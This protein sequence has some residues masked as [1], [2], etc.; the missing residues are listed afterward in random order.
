MPVRRAGGADVSHAATWPGGGPT[1][2][3]SSLGRADEQVKVRGF[4]IEPGEI[5]AALA[6]HAGVAQAAVIGRRGPARGPA[7]GGYVVP[8]RRGGGGP[9][10]RLRAHLAARLPE[11]MVPSAFVALAALPL[12]A[13]GKLDRRAL[14]APD[15][16]AGAG[17]APASPWEEILCDLFARVLG[18]EHVGV[19]DSFFDLGGHSLLATVLVARV[20]ARLGVE[21]AL[22]D[23]LRNPTVSEV[24]QLV[25]RGLAD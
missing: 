6:G 9:R 14:P 25:A 5:E 15:F 10:R 12:T 4:R 1:G 20:T 18:L 22:K 16:K 24:S 11:H 23:F 8:G 21:V 3:W 17:P 7:A 19:E 2:S 13:N